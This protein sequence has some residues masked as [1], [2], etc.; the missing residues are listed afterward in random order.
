M[1]KFIFLFCFCFGVIINVDAQCNL[2]C[3]NEVT[4]SLDADGT[5]TIFPNQV[6]EGTPNCTVFIGLFESVGGNQLLT[7][8]SS[9][10]VDC[11]LIGTFA[12]FLTGQNGSASCWGLLT[13]ED[14]IN[15]CPLNIGQDS[16]GIVYSQGNGGVSFD[17]ETTLN[18]NPVEEIY[19]WLD[20]IAEADLVSGEN[21]LEFGPSAVQNGLAGISSLDVVIAQQILLEISAADPL[22]A[23][24][25]D[26][27]DSG[28]LGVNDLVLLRQFI[29]G[30]ITELPAEDNLYFSET[31][32]FPADFD[33]FDF[34]TENYREY[35]FQD[36][37]VTQED[38]YFKVF[39]FGDINE[40]VLSDS[41]ISPSATVRSTKQLMIE[42][43]AVAQGETVLVPLSLDAEEININGLQM[44]L[45]LDN[46]SLLDVIDNY[47]GSQLFYNELS[48]S[49]LRFSFLDDATLQNFDITLELEVLEDGMLSDMISL[50][51]DFANE[52]VSY[53]AH[54][55]IDINF[56]QSSSVDEVLVVKGNVL[57]NSLEINLPIEHTA[58]IKVYNLQG[59]L[60]N[61]QLPVNNRVVLE[62]NN[63][64]ISGMYLVSTIYEGKQVSIKVVVI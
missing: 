43:R 50:N 29:L 14:T 36:S 13:I 53:D 40:A 10:V 18:G 44:S 35:R 15:A 3:L 16:L 45:N 48:S 8:D 57:S 1:K 63:F 4:V 59:R 28:F 58:A 61:S 25:A 7:I 51:A 27:D 34:T 64:P 11:N 37:D 12:Y 5:A 46:L 30:I 17:S 39:P 2:V 56:E 33:V 26:V 31:Y 20:V 23:V 62:R 9:I 21:V 19:S 22:K 55:G 60:I 24:L 49:D 42:D 32:E 47:S 54:A 38:L 6:I 52:V 41:L